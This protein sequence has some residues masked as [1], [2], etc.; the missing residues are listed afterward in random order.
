ML[1]GLR[2]T[3]SAPRAIIRIYSDTVTATEILLERRSKKKNWSGSKI[4][5]RLVIFIFFDL[6]S[7]EQ[8]PLND[9]HRTRTDQSQAR[10]HER[11]GKKRAVV[12]LHLVSSKTNQLDYWLCCRREISMIKMAMEFVFLRQNKSSPKQLRQRQRQGTKATP[13]IFVIVITIA[14]SQMLLSDA[15]LN[16]SHIS[17]L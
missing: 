7:K 2:V 17:K 11:I 13:S 12:V 15:F 10:S 8:K 4:M 9:S 1:R 6:F 14:I 16:Q 3:E 5:V